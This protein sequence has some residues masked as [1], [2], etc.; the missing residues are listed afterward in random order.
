M[1]MLCVWKLHHFGREKERYMCVWY[2]QPNMHIKAQSITRGRT[3]PICKAAQLMSIDKHVQPPRAHVYESAMF[4]FI[5]AFF[6]LKKGDKCANAQVHSHTLT[7]R[8]T[9]RGK[10]GVYHRD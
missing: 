8:R 2:T 6:F 10:K 5:Y 7:P 4:L 9:G 1:I 3:E